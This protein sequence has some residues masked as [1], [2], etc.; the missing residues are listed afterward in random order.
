MIGPVIH[1]QLCIWRQ[2]YFLGWQKGPNF[3]MTEPCQKKR[4]LRNI[5]LQLCIMTFKATARDCSLAATIRFVYL[6]INFKKSLSSK[7]NYWLECYYPSIIKRFLA[8]KYLSKC[9]V[10]YLIIHIYVSIGSFQVALTKH[11]IVVIIRWTCSW[12]SKL[13]WQPAKYLYLLIQQVRLQF[14]LGFVSFN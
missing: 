9:Y 1:T 10:Y 11:F 8:F 3:V 2:F 6:S 13:L 7:S 5:Y 14:F 4:L 12:H